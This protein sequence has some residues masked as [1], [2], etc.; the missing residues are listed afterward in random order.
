MRPSINKNI[1]H[2]PLS[3]PLLSLLS[4]SSSSSSLCPPHR[5]RPC[6]CCRHRRHRHPRRCRASASLSNRNIRHGPE[7]R[8]RSS[9][10]VQCRRVAPG[11]GLAAAGS[12]DWG[13][14]M[15]HI[16][17]LRE[18]KALVFGWLPL[19]E[20]TK[21]P[22]ERWCWRW[23]GCRRGVTTVRN[24]WGGRLLVLLGRKK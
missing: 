18:G 19:N 2:S 21:Q 15:A 23:K 22:T 13:A 7:S 1:L 16:K 17:K 11:L 24:A 20:N 8:C 4:S 6:R 14:P 12:L 5:R 3:S 10:R 9:R